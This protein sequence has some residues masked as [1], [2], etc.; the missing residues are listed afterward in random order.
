MMQTIL[1]S[2]WLIKKGTGSLDEQKDDFTAIPLFL[3]CLATSLVSIQYF[4]TQTPGTLKDTL[5]CLTSLYGA[6]Y[7]FHAHERGYKWATMKRK[8]NLQTLLQNIVNLYC[9]QRNV[10]FFITTF[11]NHLIINNNA[12]DDKIIESYRHQIIN[13]LTI[14]NKFDLNI[15]NH[16]HNITPQTPSA[17][18]TIKSLRELS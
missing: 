2:L 1:H 10:V 13:A 7:L 15:D 14:K 11:N 18:Q 5:I 8:Q 3:L 6:F 16:N 17:H 12:I 4:Q 9:P